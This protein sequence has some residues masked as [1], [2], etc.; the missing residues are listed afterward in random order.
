MLSDK[1]GSKVACLVK[2]GGSMTQDSCTAVGDDLVAGVGAFQALIGHTILDSVK[3]A[4]NDGCSAGAKHTC[5]ETR[6]GIVS[7]WQ[8]YSADSNLWV[9]VC[10]GKK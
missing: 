8:I 1:S 5:Q 4:P 3:A 2:P 6:S 9:I 7:T 10:P